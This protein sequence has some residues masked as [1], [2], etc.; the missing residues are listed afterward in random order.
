MGIHNPLS[1]DNIMLHFPPNKL[2]VVYIGVCDWGEVEHLQEVLPLLYGFTKEQDANN[3]KNM[4][5][6]IVK[7]LF[8]FIISRE[9]QIPLNEWPNNVPQL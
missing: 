2:D 7:E 3:T 1:K 5:W 4:R 9:L 8:L 6:C